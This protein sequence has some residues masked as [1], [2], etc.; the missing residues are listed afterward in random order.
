MVSQQKRALVI[1]ICLFFVLGSNGVFSDSLTIKR[2]DLKS[3]LLGESVDKIVQIMVYVDTSLLSAENIKRVEATGN[4]EAI[5]V[6][7]RSISDRDLIEAQINQGRF[8]EAYIAMKAI[9]DR[10]SALIK[11]SWLNE[12]KFQKTRNLNESDFA[13]SDV[14][15]KY[16]Q[17]NALVLRD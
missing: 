1:A 10:I 17:R 16:A 8:E 5:A 12:Y 11:L 3:Q 6:L 9:E 7:H 13:V 14:Y 2:S 4:Y 15:F